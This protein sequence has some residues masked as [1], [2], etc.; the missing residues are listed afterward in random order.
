[1]I[2][3][4]AADKEEES[5][6]SVD[7]IVSPTSDV[8]ASVNCVSIIAIFVAAAVC[9]ESI[10]CINVVVLEDDVDVTGQE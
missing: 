9:K 5:I 4:A 3:V 8:A 10:T 6:I 1:M 2:V 7:V